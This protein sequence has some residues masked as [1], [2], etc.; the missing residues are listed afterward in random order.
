MANTPK[1]IIELEQPKRSPLTVN[2]LGIYLSLDIEAA[3]IG[4][5]VNPVLAANTKIIT[6]VA[7]TKQKAALSPN[8]CIAN[9]D[10]PT[11]PTNKNA[12]IEPIA[13]NVFT[14]LLALGS[15]KLVT[16]FEIAS[17]PV[18]DEAP[19]E[20]AFNSKNNVTPGT[21]VPTDACIC[22]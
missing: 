11:I 20:N 1:I 15:L 14:A 22:G 3:N 17:T 7:C 21:A 5:A 19:D 18:N 9:C 8:I 16:A 13:I 10:K 6:V 4:K 12:K 2:I